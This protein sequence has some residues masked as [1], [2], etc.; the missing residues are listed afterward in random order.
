LPGGGGHL[1]VLRAQVRARDQGQ[2]TGADGGMSAMSRHDRMR[3]GA[4]L[5]AALMVTLAACRGP[6]DTATPAAGGS[7]PWPAVAWP[8]PEDA[9]LEQRLDDLLATMTVEE[10][11]GQLVQ[12]DIA[13]VTP[14]DVRR[15]RLGS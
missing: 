2:G 12:G 7:D 11:V 9:A 3:C 15:Y 5:L 10:K 6:G 1:G 13:S 8:L 14:E 4:T